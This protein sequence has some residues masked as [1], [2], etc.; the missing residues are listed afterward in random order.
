M[1]AYYLRLPFHDIILRDLL[2]SCDSSDES[3][4]LM[5]PKTQ[6]IIDLLLDLPSSLPSNSQFMAMNNIY[7]HFLPKQ[8]HFELQHE[9][10]LCF[11]NI[12]AVVASLI[13]ALIRTIFI[14]LAVIYVTR[15]GYVMT[16][17]VSRD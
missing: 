15:T 13:L 7:R 3:S 8:E 10:N 1:M 11:F 4:Y 12:N 2:E 14:A 17:I 9:L 16:S 6:T 5:W